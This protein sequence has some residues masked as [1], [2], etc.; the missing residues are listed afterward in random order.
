M[1]ATVGDFL[2][3]GLYSW[4][5]T[6]SLAISSTRLPVMGIASSGCLVQPLTL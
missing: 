1:A 6:A 2:V 4:G 5:V 3:D